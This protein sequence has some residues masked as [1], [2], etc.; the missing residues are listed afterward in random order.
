[1]E[2]NRVEKK[3][4]R[5]GVPRRERAGPT[6]PDSLA[7]WGVLVRPP[8]FHFVSF[9]TQALRLDLKP[10]IYTPDGVC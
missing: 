5:N 2:I 6:R 3:P 9:S 8:D 1:M 10:S 4:G 7:T